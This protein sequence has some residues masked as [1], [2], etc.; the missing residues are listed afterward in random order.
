VEGSSHDIVLAFASDVH[1]EPLEY[2]AGA[3]STAIFGA[4]G[5]GRLLCR[6]V[7]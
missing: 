3:V 6:Y 2:E 4:S 1:T 7:N 5:R